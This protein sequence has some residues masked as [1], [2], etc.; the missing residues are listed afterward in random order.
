MRFGCCDIHFTPY[1]TLQA[2]KFKMMYIF[3]FFKQNAIQHFVKRKSQV[4]DLAFEGQLCFRLLRYKDSNTR[5]D[6]MQVNWKSISEEYIRKGISVIPL[7]G[8]NPLNKD[9]SKWC[10]EKQEF[11]ISSSN[12]TGIGVCLGPA[13]NLMALDIDYD[14]GRVLNIFPISPIVKRG[15]KG[16]TRFFQYRKFDG[17]KKWHG[18][19]FEILTEGNQ[20]VVPPSIHPETNVSYEWMNENTLLNFDLDLLPVLDFDFLKHFEHQRSARHD[21][22]LNQGIAA[23]HK[24]KSIDEVA[25]EL[26]EYDIKMHL[27]KAWIFDDKKAKDMNDAFKKMKEWVSGIGKTIKIDEIKP[28]DEPVVKEKF[29]ILTYPVLNGLFGNIFNLTREMSYTDVPNICF[30]SALSSFSTAMG[31]Q[32][33]FEDVKANLFNLIIA[34][35]GTGKKFAFG[36]A[37]KILNGLVASADY[38]SS[39]ALSSTLYDDIVRLD[40]SEEISK[41]FK[42][43][44][45]ANAWQSTLPQDLCRL[46]SASV[47]GFDMPVVKNKVEGAS[48]SSQLNNVFIGFLAATTGSEFKES[49]RRA[50]FTSGFIPRFLFFIDEPKDIIKHTL[51]YKRI[52][53]L[54]HICKLKLNLLSKRVLPGGINKRFIE[55]IRFERLD[56]EKVFVDHMSEFH[57]NSYKEDNELLKPILSRFR[58]QYKKLA[59]ISA[60]NRDDGNFVTENDLHWAKEVLTVC[61][62]NSKGL[63]AVA[64]AENE[65]ESYKERIVNLIKMNPGL[66]RSELTRRTQFLASGMRE[67]LIKDLVVAERIVYTEEVRKTKPTQKYWVC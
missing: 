60:V 38:A 44:G 23:L 66:T 29:K 15:K 47:E 26:L 40:I 42:L 14:E 53:E 30:A 37:K 13:S 11:P 67:S 65:I 55:P 19:G 33:I 21:T 1:Q 63:F 22:L 3:Y 32:F 41:L 48:K 24:G 12:Q 52:D 46:W 61:Y 9:W 45:G 49:A 36:S 34:D 39:P 25:E 20:T 51:D 2:D 5:G 56:C 4:V 10:Y 16:E 50:A 31:N 27:P 62:H 58:E 6:F 8:K 59:L 43:A 17:K 54:T 64:G 35:S 57:T 7:N 28:I 18:F